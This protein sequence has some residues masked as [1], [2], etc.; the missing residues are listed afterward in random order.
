MTG[1]TAFL[2]RADYTCYKENMLGRIYFD[3]DDR[4]A[5][6]APMA[7]YRAIV[8]SF[9]RAGTTSVQAGLLRQQNV[10]ATSSR[11]NRIHRS[12]G[13]NRFGLQGKAT[14]V[15]L[16]SFSPQSGFRALNNLPAFQC[17][18]QRAFAAELA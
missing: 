10:C 18:A 14:A 6:H 9:Q 13:E 1:L 12:A 2:R 15:A 5:L 11:I 7:K 4:G 3:G 16:P 8:H 17:R